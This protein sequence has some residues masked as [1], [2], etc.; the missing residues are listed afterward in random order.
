MGIRTG[1]IKYNLNE[2]GRHLI[3]QPRN[4]NVPAVCKLINGGKV[5]EKISAGDMVGY[6]GH[7]V[8]IEYGINPP[9]VTLQGGALVPIEPAI[10]TVFMRAHD[11][12]T[13]EHEAEFLDTPL[14]KKAQE[15]FQSKYGGF[16]SVF[17]PNERNPTSFEGFDYVSSPNFQFNRGYTLDSAASEKDA[18][19]RLTSR[20]RAEYYNG[21]LEEMQAVMDSLVSGSMASQAIV[22]QM[23]E[24]NNSLTQTVESLSNELLDTRD[25]LRDAQAVIDSLQ[26]KFEPMMRLS[27]SRDSNWVMDSIHGFEERKNEI[28][29]GEGNKYIETDAERLLYEMG[30]K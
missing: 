21:K 2:R 15:W 14:G 29:N 18:I 11:D 27:I 13:I 5:Q 28:V 16:S 8:R 7:G 20:Q 4:F 12:G 26:P 22:R 24:L 9:E 6:L 25:E 30:Y 17:L 23:T 1:I 3:G 10:R 19:S